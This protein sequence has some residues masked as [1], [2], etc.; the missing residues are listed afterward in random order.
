[1]SFTGWFILFLTVQFIH[2]LGTWKLYEKAGR[3]AWE[4]AIPVY[5][6]IVLLGIIKRPKWWVILLFIPIVNLIMF[7]VLWIETC[8]SF[9]YTTTKDTFL[10]ILTLGFYIAYINYATD[11][12]YRP[13]R[14]LKAPTVVGEWVSSIAFA[15]IAA[16]IVHNYFIR[17]YVIPSSSLE[18]TLL[19]G[20][21][22]FVSK[23]HYGARVPMSTVALPMI[24][25]TIPLVKSKSYVFS[26]DY[27]NRENAFANKFQL[28]YMRLPGLTS[29]K[30]NDIVV[31]GQPADTLRD[32]NK[33]T[34]DRSYYK[35]IDKKLNLVKRCVGIA[36][37]SLEIR[38]GYIYIN[39]ERS[40]LPPNAKPQWYH[41]I[42]T[43]G[44]KFSEAALMR[45]N[46]RFKEAYTT[47]DGKY[48]LNLTDEEAALIA[49]N[50]IV[51]SVTKK[52]D[53]KDKSD[54]EL[55][56]Q[57]PLYRWN[58]DNFGPIYIP[59]KGATVSITKETIPFYKRIIREYEKN[60]LT[61]V[62]DDIYI[63]G[64]KA[65]SYTFKQDYYWMMGDNRQNS[66]D[67][68]RWGYVPF[69]H[70]IGKP[71][72]VW[73]SVDNE[74]GKIRWDR[75]FMTVTNGESKSYFWLGILS[76]ALILFF[77]FKPKKKKA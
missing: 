69:D 26:D 73:F 30:R 47:Q 57:S 18:K 75:I 38:D 74:T 7:P 24:H 50:P 77:V 10:A 39:G 46:V 12:Q 48:L 14:E 6:A 66:L 15:I 22:L 31:F 67:A 29:I 16:T 21:Y 44:Q 71:I 58:I 55:F 62:N 53:P 9:G 64:K 28:P 1:M 37:D 19:I 32:M 49:K 4:A 65:D 35:P 33:L 59:K 23:F 8:R 13:D 36:G 2:F 61:F 43:E 51:K 3:K 40:I 52:I 41:I 34:P 17:P 54:L 76:A 27:E 63:N 11:A 56:P 42:D 68:R 70:V 45:Y 5:N 72:M 20:D 25:D 60:D